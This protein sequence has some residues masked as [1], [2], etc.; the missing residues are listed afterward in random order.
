MGVPQVAQFQYRFGQSLVDA[1]MLSRDRLATAA[2]E[3]ATRDIALARLL[4]ESG[5][6]R[7]SDALRNVA[8]SLGVEFIDPTVNFAPDEAA[9]KRL[10]TSTAV[11]ETALPIR[12]H[13]GVLVVAVPDPLDDTVRSRVETAARGEV[14]LVLGPRAELDEA[15][16][17]FYMGPGSATGPAVHIVTDHFSPVVPAEA[18]YH[19]NDL[20]EVLIAQGGS[21]LHLTAGIPPKIRVNGSLREVEGY[22]PLRPAD[23]RAMIYGILTA[24]QKEQLE[25]ELE[26][27]AS[28]PV[29][30]RGRFRVNV[31][32]QRSSIGAVLRAIPN[33]ILPLAELGMPPVVQELTE[34]PRGLVLVTGSTGSG[35]S[36]TLASMIDVINSTRA[37]HI[38]TVEDPIEFMHSHKMA[39]VNQREVGSDTTTFAQALRHTL[40]QDPDV[41]LVGEMRDLET[42][43]TA[44]TAAETGHL[45]FATLHTQDAPGSVERIIDVFPPHQ[46]QQVRVQLA[47]SLAGVVTQQL[48]PTIDGRGRVAAVEVMIAIPAV[49]NMIREG[50]VHQIRSA[51]QAGG[52]YGMQTMDSSLAALV[53]S[54][55]VDM[56]QASERAQHLDEFMNLVG[57]GAR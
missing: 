4:V 45:V 5:S 34:L 43:S 8:E 2:L 47:E 36:T 35:K 40:R 26:L 39:I 17:R 10:D 46:Q 23:L 3:A 24:R 7:R 6:V 41:I 19:L 15:V 52:R 1:G 29:P 31:F 56:T 14:R 30:G 12:I 21:D 51:M 20:L 18:E 32:F 53:R 28:H 27:D 44:L 42:M 22:A 48:L 50:K 49:R 25:D 16:R 57:G 38:M 37:V 13:Q 11:S 33:K 54:G 55:K 9:I